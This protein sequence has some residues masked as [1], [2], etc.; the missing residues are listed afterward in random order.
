MAR[1]VLRGRAWKFGDNVNT[2]LISPAQYMELDYETIG[3]HAMEGAMPGF[4]DKIS[5]GDFIVAGENFGCGSS[6]E[7]AQ[8]ALRYAG[9]G[10]VIAKSFARIFFRNCINTGLPALELEAVDRIEQGDELE[11]DL[12]G[13]EV[14]NLSKGE[15]YAVPP[16]PPKVRELVDAGGLIPYLKAKLKC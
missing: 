11:I 3:Q 1:G 8:I 9:V 13:G 2:D 10:A 6:R 14:R 16:L 12:A 4:A 5:K 15:S 7:T